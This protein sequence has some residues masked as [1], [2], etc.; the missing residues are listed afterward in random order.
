MSVTI[1]VTRITGAIQDGWNTQLDGI[2]AHDQQE[3]R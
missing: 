2:D 3:A 1:T